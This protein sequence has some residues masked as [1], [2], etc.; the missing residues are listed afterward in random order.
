MYTDFMSFK[1]TGIWMFNGYKSMRPLY[2]FSVTVDITDI[3]F[4][5]F[6]DECQKH[7]CVNPVDRG[8]NGL[9]FRF[10]YTS[11]DDATEHYG[12]ISLTF[13]ASTSRL[14]VQGTS[15]LLWIDEH[16]PIIY[17]K[18]ERAYEEDIG[19]WRSLA[20]RRGIGVKRVTRQTLRGQGLPSN[21]MDDNA[22]LP[23]SPRSPTTLPS[24]P[25]TIPSSPNCLPSSSDQVSLSATVSPHVV[26]DTPSVASHDA[27]SPPIPGQE[28]C[29]TSSLVP[30]LCPLEVLP[31]DDP[32]RGDPSQDEP[33]REDVVRLDVPV[34]RSK[35][36]PTK[37]GESSGDTVVKK[38]LTIKPKKKSKKEGKA[39]VRPADATVSHQAKYPPGQYCVTSCSLK[40]TENSDMIRCSVC[41][42]W[43]HIVCTGEDLKYVGV[44]A[45]SD[46]RKLPSL[47]RDLV[48]QVSDLKTYI[49][50]SKDHDQ[51]LK[52]EIHRLKSENGNL[53]QKVINMENTNCEL[54]KLIETMSECDTAPENL[55]PSLSIPRP[56]E[57]VCVPMVSTKNRFVPLD[58]EGDRAGVSPP[59]EKPA[60]AARHRQPQQRPT[61][62]PVTVTVIGSSIV[63]GV[64]PLVQGQGFEATGYVFPG[65]TARQINGSLRN[66]PTSDITVLAA[67][68]NNIA[69]Q[70]VKQCIDEIRQVIDNLS[71]KR[72][73][74][75]VIM[76]EIPL[77]HDRPALNSKIMDVNKFIAGE[78]AKRKNWYLLSH[79]LRKSDYKSDG[80]HL[81]D[82][83]CAKYSHEIRHVIRRTRVR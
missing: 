9:Q 39:K 44:W 12:T 4:L 69:D 73:N 54:R 80:L 56:V 5:A 82:V 6:V 83:G 14:L 2:D 65:R 34:T 68:S 28:L 47:V 70:P 63:R 51:S 62:K 31:A 33:S 79:D 23:T 57:N 7:Y 40:D 72:V 41:M 52:A 50:D 76:A 13:Y 38:T 67:G 8:H 53:K 19:K 45:C 36:K 37:Q 22:V 81:N 29:L 77:R 55:N 27:P 42:S 24:S 3:M 75:T 64:A 61:P 60:H 16:L 25:N 66:I 35:A 58:M 30:P 32:S 71:R 48:S 18:A 20:R 59:T 21:P 26:Y 74:R 15:Y 11:P 17:T 78:V 49:Q 10:E 43:F 1:F 46:C